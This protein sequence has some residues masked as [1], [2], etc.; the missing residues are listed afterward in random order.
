MGKER[1]GPGE[2]ERVRQFV[3]TREIAHVADRRWRNRAKARAFR[4]RHAATGS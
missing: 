4:E 2:L 1:Q 3:D